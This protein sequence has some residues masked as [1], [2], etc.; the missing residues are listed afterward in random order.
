MLATR[1]RWVTLCQRL[2]ARGN[3]SGGIT[4]DSTYNRLVTAYNGSDRHYHNINHISDGLDELDQS[5]HLAEYPDILEMAWWWHDFIYN[6]KSPINE[7]KSSIATDLRLGKLGLSVDIRNR[8][9]WLIMTTK[10]DH[11]PEDHDCRLIIDIDLASLSAP[12]KIFDKNTANI[13]KEYR[14]AV[15]DDKI[16]AIG[17]T[18]FFEKLLE[19]RHSIY[20][21]DYFRNKYE[22]QAQENLKRIIAKHKN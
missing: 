15:P 10:H 6:A 2:Q 17:R 1:E 16:F 7:Y 5:R 22:A 9:G 11:I 4:V 12:P 20:L 8:A 18:K 21:T 3:I 19:N 14:T 13:R